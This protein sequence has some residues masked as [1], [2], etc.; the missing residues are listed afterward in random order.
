MS[1]L[2]PFLFF[3]SSRR[4]HTRFKCDWSS[5][6]CSSDL[7]PTACI[8]GPLLRRVCE[9]RLSGDSRLTG[10][11]SS[12]AQAACVPEGHDLGGLSHPEPSSDAA[13]AQGNYWQTGRDQRDA[14]RWT[15]KELL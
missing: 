9:T 8:L 14:R 3:F 6:V 1:L 4:R 5:D 15:R 7:E 2:F 10:R 13:A 11:R 12:E